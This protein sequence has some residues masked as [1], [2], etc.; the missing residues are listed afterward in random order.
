L[1]R[2]NLLIINPHPSLISRWQ[3]STCEKPF[4]EAKFNMEYKTEEINADDYCSLS[5][6]GDYFVT[7]CDPPLPS[8]V[9]DNE[10][11]GIYSMASFRENIF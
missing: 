3:L 7:F 6:D 4:L 2:L 9:A 5:V 1:I 11:I 8:F 10:T